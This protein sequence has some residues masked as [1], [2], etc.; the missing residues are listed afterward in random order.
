[1]RIRVIVLGGMVAAGVSAC[2]AVHKVTLPDPSV[3]RT[4]EIGGAAG[5]GNRTG[6]GSLPTQPPAP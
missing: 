2:D 4:D 5:S 3:L 1:M 6:S